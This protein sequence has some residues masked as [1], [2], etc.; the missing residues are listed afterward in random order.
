MVEVP[1]EKLLGDR[2]INGNVMFLSILLRWFGFVCQNC[3]KVP[4]IFGYSVEFDFYVEF[5][6]VEFR[7]DWRYFDG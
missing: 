5:G 4:C 1:L 2:I 7:T 6:L 3:N